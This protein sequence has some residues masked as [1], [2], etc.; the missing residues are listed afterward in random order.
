[1]KNISYDQAM[2]LANEYGAKLIDV[3]LESDYYEKH[4]YGSV[5]IPVENI[6][7]DISNVIT[8]KN[9]ILVVYCLK[10][11]RSIAACDILT[12]LG[13]INVY[14]IQGGIEY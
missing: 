9:E 8:N 5:N 11:I 10:G 13:Y 4:L 14:N 1:M 12:R 3:Q 6:A 7:Y 2:Q